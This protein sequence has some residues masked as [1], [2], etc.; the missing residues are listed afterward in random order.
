MANTFKTLLYSL[1][2]TSLSMAA[3]AQRSVP[4]SVR[5][6][7][8]L[9]AG[10]PN[11]DFGKSYSALIGAS[12]HVD[13]PVTKKIYVTASAGYN[14][15]PASSA[16]GYT[17]PQSIFNVTPPDFKTIP[18]KVGI[19]YFLIGGFYAQGEVG[20]TLLANKKDLYA[21]YGNAF[22]Y[23]PQLGMLF[24]LKNQMYIDGGVRYEGVSSFYND[25]SK[26]SFW[27]AHVSFA[28]NL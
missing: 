21:L 26:F 19:K 13:I 9:D 25:N 11:G 2:F 20:E 4:D 3:N 14:M 15:F 16:S 22:T 23:A 1:L 18:L 7:V 10:I 12:L 28:F 17:N 8:G 6:S 27:A 24:R 5:I